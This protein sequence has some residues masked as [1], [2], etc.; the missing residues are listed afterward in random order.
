MR[1]GIT[2]VPFDKLMYTTQSIELKTFLTLGVK[3]Q[4]WAYI[5]ITS[6]KMSSD[7]LFHS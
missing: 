6:I 7:D 5:Y 3:I 2:T 4:N 1:V